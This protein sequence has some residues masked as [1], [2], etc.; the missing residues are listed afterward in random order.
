[1]ASG[2]N[3]TNTNLNLIQDSDKIDSADINAIA[4]AVESARVKIGRAHV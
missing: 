3:L 2:E 4:Q 1:M